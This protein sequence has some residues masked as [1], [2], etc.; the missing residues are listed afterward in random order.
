MKKGPRKYG[1]LEA[2]IQEIISILK[3]NPKTEKVVLFGS[4]AKGNFEPGSDIDLAWLGADLN[5][6]DTFAGSH[7]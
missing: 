1:I 7:Q 3:A 5:L 6:K 4:R 2:D